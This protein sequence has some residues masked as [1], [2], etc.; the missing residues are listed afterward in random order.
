MRRRG[1]CSGR[2]LHV[3][4][5]QAKSLTV[6]TLKRTAVCVGHEEVAIPVEEHKGP[7]VLA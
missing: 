2:G 4:V 7:A 6:S 3:K 1:S 5:P